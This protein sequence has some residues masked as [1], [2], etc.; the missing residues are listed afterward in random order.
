VGAHSN[1]GIH[2]LDRCLAGANCLAPDLMSAE[3]RLDEVAQILAAGLVRLLQKRE[4]QNDRNMLEKNSLDFSP[5]RSVHATARQR[6][7]VRR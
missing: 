6:R 2:A 7:E 3:E 5:D 1:F 4:Y